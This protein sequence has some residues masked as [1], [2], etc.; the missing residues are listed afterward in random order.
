MAARRS[1][2]RSVSPK[3]KAKQK[4]SPQ[5]PNAKEKVAA[6]DK[7]RAALPAFGRA[8]SITFEGAP[9]IPRNQLKIGEEIGKGR[10]KTAFKGT[11][12]DPEGLGE[13]REV[14]VVRYA[15]KDE[16]RRE[17]KALSMLANKG[18]KATPY[19]PEIFG[20]CDERYEVFILEELAKFGSVKGAITDPV[21]RSQL[22]TGHLL[23]MS[24]QTAA[25]MAFLQSIR[26]IHADLSCRNLLLFNL[27]EDPNDTCVKVTDFGLAILL[28]EGATFV[29]RNQPHAT[30]WCAPEIISHNRMSFPGEVWGFGA[31]LWELFSFGVAPWVNVEK[32]TEVSDR[33]TQLGEHAIATEDAEG[34]V[35]PDVSGEFPKQDNCPLKAHIALLSCL[36]VPMRSRASTAELARTFRSLADAAIAGEDIDTISEIVEEPPEDT[37]AENEE[38]DEPSFTDDSISKIAPT[39]EVPSQADGFFAQCM[40]LK[41]FLESANILDLLGDAGSL[42]AFKEF[43]QLRGEARNSEIG[44]HVTPKWEAPSW[45]ES[46]HTDQDAS[47]DPVTS[48]KTLR[49]RSRNSD[50]GGEEGGWVLQSL[51]G[52]KVCRSN[53]KN[54]QQ[55][56]TAYETAARPGTPCMLRGPTGDE[57]AGQSWVVVDRTTSPKSRRNFDRSSGTGVWSP[58]PSLPGSPKASIDV[59]GAPLT[60]SFDQQVRPGR[61]YVGRVGTRGGLDRWHSSIGTEPAM[62][63]APSE[64][65]VSYRFF[66]PRFRPVSPVKQC[67]LNIKARESIT[68]LPCG[69]PIS[70]SMTE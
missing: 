11:I 6:S 3:S 57:V 39:A 2:S 36:R 23:R 1:V 4:A 14:V 28:P 66:Q 48:V 35:I 54:Q 16:Q 9:I 70:S 49:Q 42:D 15:K 43:V 56:W 37:F 21:I 59:F 47:A 22:S 8:A 63:N 29:D 34:A 45:E 61:G 32:R 41:D 7:S 24:E 12:A 60:T 19:V 31:T 52:D 5:K 46:A 10:F 51:V 58:A 68:F 18:D 64:D 69:R 44:K 53:F 26:I 20:Q 17:L 13:G 25:G 67:D 50:P 55:A 30:R 27:T 40:K 62:G 33:L 38:N 65:I